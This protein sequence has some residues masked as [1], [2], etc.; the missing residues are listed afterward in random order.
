MWGRWVFAMG[1]REEQE[2]VCLLGFLGFFFFFLV[3][4]FPRKLKGLW[5]CWRLVCLLGLWVW[6]AREFGVD[7]VRIWGGTW[8]IQWSWF[9]E[10]YEE[11]E[12]HVLMFFQINNETQNFFKLFNLIRFNVF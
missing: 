3:I 10:E 12:E 5:V 8:R 4:C 1:L 9:G 2:K 6:F 7:C 11:H